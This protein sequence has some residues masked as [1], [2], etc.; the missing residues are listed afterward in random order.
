MNASV[1]RA[2]LGCVLLLLVGTP[3]EGQL[4]DYP[5]AP[6]KP[7]G[8]VVAPFFDGWYGNGDGTV[9]YSF[10]FLN[11]NTDEV[12]DIPLGP[13]NY[14]EPAEYD[15]VQPTHFPVFDRPGF[16]GKRDRGSFAVTAPAGTE[17]VWTLTHAGHTYSIPGRATSTAYEMSREAAAHGSLPPSIRFDSD[18]PESVDREGIV[19]RRTTTSVG[20]PITLSVLVQ[21]RG[22]REDHH[23]YPVNT[24]WIWHQG[25][26]EIDLQPESALIESEGW[27]LSTTQATFS[28][29]GQ[30]MIRVRA[31]NFE[32]ED[33][34]FDDQCC[35]SNVFFPITVTP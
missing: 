16:I 2:T 26:A 9:T 8:D 18:G 24:T 21:D 7:S 27:G 29:P 11:R 25:P 10:G 23:L 12:V 33:S 34:S 22:I 30:Y 32:A 19:A 14:I 13:N 28:E 20:T 1:A 6:L 35:W 3:S 5:L 17:V 15:G 4:P 31:D